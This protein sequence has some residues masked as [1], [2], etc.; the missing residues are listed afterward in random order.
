[1]FKCGCR[2]DPAV[3]GYRLVADYRCRGWVFSLQEEHFLHELVDEGDAYAYV[4]R[5]HGRDYPK[6]AGLLR[7]GVTDFQ[8]VLGV[9]VSK[10]RESVQSRKALFYDLLK[11]LLKE[12]GRGQQTEQWQSLRRLLEPNAPAIQV[13]MTEEWGC[14]KGAMAYGN[15]VIKREVFCF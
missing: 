12:A 8:V 3:I 14:S 6:R 5:G 1:M 10:R 2:R 13:T 9:P 11:V 15:S 4:G 7:P